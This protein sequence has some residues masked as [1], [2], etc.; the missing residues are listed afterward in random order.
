MRAAG[1]AP[2]MSVVL[3]QRS[4]ESGEAMDPTQIRILVAMGLMSLL[5]AAQVALQTGGVVALP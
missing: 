4:V 5:F 3:R 1:P 2:I